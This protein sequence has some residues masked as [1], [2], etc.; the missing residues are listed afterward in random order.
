MPEKKSWQGFDVYEWNPE[1]T[2]VPDNDEDNND[3]YS[4]PS[5]YSTYPYVQASEYT[6][7]QQV[8]NWAL[9]ITRVNG[10]TP[11][12]QQKITALQKEA[13]SNKA[14]YMLKAIRFVQDDIRYMGIE[15]GEYSHRP[16]APEKVLTQR[17]GDCKDKSLL[18]CAL[19][20]ANGI[21][22]NLTLVN[23]FA[24]AKVAEWLPSPVLFNHAIVFAVLDGK[25]YWIDPTINYQRGSLAALTVP[26]YQ[27]GLII[28][29]GNGVLT[30]IENNGNGRVTIT[31]TFQLPENNKRPAKLRVISDYS[32]QFADEQRSQFAE[33]SMKDQERSYLEYYKNIYGEVTAD[34]SLQITD[35]EDANQFEVAEKYTLRNA[36]KPDTTMPGRQQFYV[37][38]RLLTEQ[39]PRIESDSA[40]QPMSL[41]FPYKLDYTL[42]LQMPAE[43]SLDDPSLHIRNKYYRIDFTPSV[44]GKTV[45]LHYEYETYQDHVPAEAM[46]AYRADRQRLSEIAGFYLYW[47]PTTATTS[48]TIKPAN[49]ISWVMVVL[50]LLFAGIFGY[51]A[52]NFYKRSVLPVQQHPEQWPI[53]SW[54][55]LLGIGIMLFPFS[56]LTNM[57]NG[58]F[59]SSKSWL[60]ITQAQD[61]QVRMLVFIAEL[62]AYTFLLIYSLLLVLLFFKRRD[63]F[64]AACIIYL[65]AT[66]SVEVLSH[67]AVGTLNASYAWS[68]EEKTTI[69]T[70]LVFSA[71]WTP[72]LLKSERVKKTFVVPHPSAEDDPWRLR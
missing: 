45:K 38:A 35:V 19:L 24:K 60:V 1:M 53:G 31:E 65:L 12:L 59:F 54:L 7:W 46:A 64:P 18:L 55:V 27:K 26:D 20:Q 52:M 4:T 5:W 28:K 72:Y 2:D 50:C 3:D 58:D 33:T 57:I 69:I 6:E 70:S 34:T 40:N 36:W 51:I 61:G 22:A 13:G 63:T 32:R 48:T 17:F 16:S 11:A 25:P 15:M 30:D 9:P 66:L 8:V 68:T 49:N 10:I 67:L 39:L 23:T 56:Y 42:M 14:L 29:N 41:K 47:N 44:L 21:E 43:W 62:A 71:I 37:Q